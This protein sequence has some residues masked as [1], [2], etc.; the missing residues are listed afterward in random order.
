MGELTASLAHE[1]RQPIAAAMT[2][3]KTCLRWLG[4]DEPD[5]VEGREAAARMVKDVTRAADIISSISVLFKK[6]ALPREVVDV[7]QLIL[8]MIGMLRSEVNRHSISIRTDL[9]TDLPRV[10]AERVQV[11]QLLMNLMLNGIDAMKNVSS[12]RELTISSRAVADGV[13]ISVSDT[14]AGLGPDPVDQIFNAF[15]TTKDQGIGMGLTIS[16]SIVESHG[17]RLW[18]SRSAG[19][20]ATF[21]FSLPG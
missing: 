20:G 11:Q 12:E 9:D 15:F 13:V 6:G 21:Q 10:T 16:R 14:G 18:A 8:E 3:A 2:N 1:I 4:R 17:G 19:R 5:I 7:N